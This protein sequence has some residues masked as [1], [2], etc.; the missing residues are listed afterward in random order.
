M[1]P[2]PS[3]IQHHP[4]IRYASERENK[5]LQVQERVVIKQQVSD[6]SIPLLIFLLPKQKY[7]MLFCVV[8]AHGIA[9][10]KEPL[11]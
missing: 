5:N 8:W 7:T 6:G 11:K 9:K 3:V 1:N 10:L 2:S 4:S